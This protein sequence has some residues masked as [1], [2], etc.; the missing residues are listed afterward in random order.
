MEYK[1]FEANKTL[2]FFEIEKKIRSYCFSI[3]Q[4]Y[5]IIK[6]NFEIC[7]DVF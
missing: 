6:R 2:I 1:L 3:V 5:S 4:L 7:G